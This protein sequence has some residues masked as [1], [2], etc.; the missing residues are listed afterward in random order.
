MVNDALTEEARTSL[1]SADSAGPV[2][3]W[4][5]RVRAATIDEIK[6]AALQLMRDQGTTD[7]RFSD[8][9]RLLGMT[10]PALYRY[11]GD[12]NDLLTALIADAYDDLGHEVAVAREA[13][14]VEDVGGRFLAVAQG[15]RSWARR[16]PQRFAL[17][18][19]LP[20]P[21]YAAPEEGPITEAALRAMRQLKAIF[22]DAAQRQRL[23]RPLM[24]DV[25]E[26]VCRC[27]TEAHYEQQAE[28]GEEGVE[29]PPDTF[30]AILHA[31]SALHGFTC[32]EAYG[33]LEWMDPEARDE[34]FIG[35]VRLAAKAAGLPPPEAG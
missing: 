10:P 22:F 28:S 16:E 9:A 33:H 14:P 5:E 1:S 35:Q 6:R 24:R 30:Q 19:G 27:A 31:W 15:Y 8:V 26:A 23:D 21:G 2:A 25:G 12:R 18:F 4:R 7:F 32:L 20:V 3:P 29:F 13:L 34:L 11:F 17:I